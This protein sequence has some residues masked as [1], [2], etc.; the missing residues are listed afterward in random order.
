M[1]YVL[2]EMKDENKV[3]WIF[4]FFKKNSIFFSARLSLKSQFASWYCLEII[5]QDL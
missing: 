2:R 1:I 3:S 5:Y 4:I